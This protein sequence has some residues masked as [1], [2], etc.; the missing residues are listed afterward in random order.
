[1][2]INQNLKPLIVCI[3]VFLIWRFTPLREIPLRFLKQPNFIELYEKFF[4]VFLLLGATFLRSRIIKFKSWHSALI[5]I[6]IGFLSTA[7]SLACSW[8]TE[9]KNP[10]DA[11][12]WLSKSVEYDGAALFF[13]SLMVLTLGW[14]IGLTVFL[15]LRYWREKPALKNV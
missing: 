12:Y 4:F 6:S 9:A 7:L 13:T 8:F 11:S 15:I 3:L 2:Q 5:G 1:V 10:S 14:L